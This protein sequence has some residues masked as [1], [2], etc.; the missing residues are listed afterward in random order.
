M[1]EIE[2]NDKINISIT[3]IKDTQSNSVVSL[4]SNIL[5][6]LQRVIVQLAV[7]TGENKM[8]HAYAMS[9]HVMV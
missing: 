6:L 8:R 1:Q 2:A 7:I 4:P 3:N 9:Y 5:L